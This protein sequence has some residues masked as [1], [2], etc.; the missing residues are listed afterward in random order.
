MLP[1]TA[2]GQPATAAYIAEAHGV[3]RAHAVH[4]LS[5]AASGVTR[6]VVFLDES[7][8]PAFGLPLSFTGDPVVALPS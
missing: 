2:N 8:F 4:V 1:T 7:L 3:Y 6:I 5:I